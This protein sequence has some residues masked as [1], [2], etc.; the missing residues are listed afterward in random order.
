[1]RLAQRLTQTTRSAFIIENL[2]A[3]ALH[4]M[5]APVF[6]RSDEAAL[7]G[8]EPIS[9]SVAHALTDAHAALYSL[10]QNIPD[11]YSAKQVERTLERIEAVMDDA[12]YML[13]ASRFARHP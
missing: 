3:E 13:K 9:E 6:V 11:D 7:F 1:M 12:G 8:L 4:W 5:R 10:W 2:G